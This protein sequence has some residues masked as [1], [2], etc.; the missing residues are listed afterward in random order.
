MS[1]QIQNISSERLLTPISGFMC[2]HSSSG[3]LQEI[4]APTTTWQRIAGHIAKATKRISPRKQGKASLQSHSL[5][6][7][8]AKTWPQ[9]SVST[10]PR[11]H[12]YCS[13]GTLAAH[14]QKRP[15]KAAPPFLFFPQAETYCSILYGA[16]SMELLKKP[17][18]K[19]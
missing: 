14:W 4:L 6:N 13:N 3:P 16:S 19:A 8:T 9:S 11:I 7:Y 1:S 2:A 5:Q 15:Q 17:H 18:S 10:T 12:S